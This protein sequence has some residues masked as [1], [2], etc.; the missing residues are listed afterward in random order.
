MGGAYVEQWLGAVT[1][2]FLSLFSRSD[3]NRMGETRDGFGIE[4]SDDYVIEYNTLPVSPSLPN[5][6]IPRFGECRV[7]SVLRV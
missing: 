1:S 3:P 4:N 6:G 2:F 5:S 7:D